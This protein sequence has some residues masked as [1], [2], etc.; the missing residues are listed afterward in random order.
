MTIDVDRTVRLLS[1]RRRSR[2][3]LG[4][5]LAAR[6][7]TV[8][9]ESS[10]TVTNAGQRRRGRPDIRAGLDLDSRA[11]SIRHA[12][13]DDRAAVRR[14]ARSRRSGRS[15]TTRTSGR[16]PPIG[17]SSR[18]RR[19]S[20]AADGQYRSKIGL[21]PARALLDRRQLRC[22]RARADAAC[23]TTRP[24]DATGYV[25]SMWEMQT[26]AVQGGRDQQLQRRPAGTRQAAAR[27]VLR[28]RDVFA[29][30]RARAGRPSHS[31][32]RIRNGP[33]RSIG[34]LRF[35]PGDAPFTAGQRADGAPSAGDPPPPSVDWPVVTRNSTWSSAARSWGTTFS[36]LSQTGRRPPLRRPSVRRRHAVS[37]RRTRSRPQLA[38]GFGRL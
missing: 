30:A 11:C 27:S 17:W 4:A 15:S 6:V 20:S 38:V 1:S 21:S 36:P 16:F 5:L 18:S 26:R 19:C 31:R 9:F 2:T 24:A 14:P 34:G 23:S 22:R 25:N 3:T 7:R 29:G 32:V 28:A 13:H 37:R 33:I 12:E 10:N 35:G 8:A